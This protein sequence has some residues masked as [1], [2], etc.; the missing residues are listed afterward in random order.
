MYYN[1]EEVK[2]ALAGLS[3]AMELILRL[4]H[5]LDEVLI[6]PSEDFERLLLNS[7]RLEAKEQ[8][9]SIENVAD[10]QLNRNE[11]SSALNFTQKEIKE[12]PRFKD[13]KIRAKKKGYEIRYRKHGY[14]KSFY[15]TTL[16]VAKEKARQWLELLSAELDSKEYFTIVKKENDVYTKRS[17]F[18]TFA[19]EYMLKIKKPR[20]KPATWKSYYLNF[21]NYILPTFGSYQMHEITPLKIQEYLNKLTTKVP[22]ACEDVKML[23]NNIFTFAVNSN[24]LD[25]NPLVAVYIPKHERKQ[26]KALTME[27]E[28]QLVERLKGTKLE[29]VFLVALYSGA[30]PGELAS[31]TFNVEENTMTIKNGKLKQWQKELY[32]TIPIFPKLK[33]LL[34]RLTTEK[35]QSLATPKRLESFEQYCPGFT[36]KDL[37]HT[38]TTR[39]KESKIADEIVSIFT[40]HSLKSLTARVYTHYSIEFLQAEAKKLDY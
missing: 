19:L 30:R 1:Q 33:P 2:K 20:V 34:P 10:L 21:K 8:S 14:Q 16:A 18:S 35:W 37:R 31:I 28:R 12:M 15:G 38:F 24:V 7:E 11:K 3:S 5:T 25:R 23:L 17:R 27:E 6:E 13:C 32:R 9:R 29:L 22:R 36:P 39:A 4:S 26:G 40:G